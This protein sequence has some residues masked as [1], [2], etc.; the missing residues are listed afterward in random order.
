M[1]WHSVTRPWKSD[2]LTVCETVLDAV[3]TARNRLRN[4]FPGGADELC[5]LIRENAT[6][7]EAIRDS[8]RK[9]GNLDHPGRQFIRLTDPE[10]ERDEGL[11]DRPF[12]AILGTLRERMGDT[13]SLEAI[14]DILIEHYD[15]R[16]LPFMI[17]VL[18]VNQVILVDHETKTVKIGSHPV[19]LGCGLAE[20]HEENRL[21]DVHAAP[22]AA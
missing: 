13:M 11:D 6:E 21:S 7:V 18:A 15:E 16:F 17:T 1:G 8:V 9:Y 10:K 2:I 3:S 12:K 14:G 19:F 5:K 20:N 4:R 22:P